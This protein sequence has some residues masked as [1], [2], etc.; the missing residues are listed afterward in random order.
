M[1]N[2]D[3]MLDLSHT[4]LEK[5]F[6]VKLEKGS[7]NLPGIADPYVLNVG[8]DTGYRLATIY[9]D[10]E[11]YPASNMPN[12]R[13]MLYYNMESVVLAYMAALPKK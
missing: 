5:G 1:T 4:L 11:I 2:F 9:G 6:L 12:D 7:V 3:M 10:F 13:M 8:T